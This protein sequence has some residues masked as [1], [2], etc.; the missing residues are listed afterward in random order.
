[1]TDKQRGFF[2]PVCA[3]GQN[4]ISPPN[5]SSQQSEFRQCAIGQLNIEDVCA[6]VSLQIL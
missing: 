4:T 6:A 2:H 5:K 3:Y 1:M